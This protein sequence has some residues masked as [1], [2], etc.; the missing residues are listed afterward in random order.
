MKR[1]NRRIRW[2]V[3]LSAALVALY[4]A[5]ALRPGVWLRDAFLYQKPDGSLSGRDAYGTYAMTI[6]SIPEG[7][8]VDFSLN[9][10][11]EQYRIE[12]SSEKMPEQTVKIYRDH[13]LC[14]SGTAQGEPEDALL[15]KENGGLADDIRVVVNGEYSREDLLPTCQWLYCVAV[16]GRRETR[17]DLGFLFPMALLGLLLAMDLK[18]PLLFWNLRHALEVNGGEPSDWY[19]SCQKWSRVAMAGGILVLA[20]ISFSVH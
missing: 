4:L 16:G 3:L 11:S 19:Y 8:V 13:T 9:G 14:F 20:V 5:A 12:Q 15:W 18:W 10:I 7:T 17:G 6:V 1:S 2:T